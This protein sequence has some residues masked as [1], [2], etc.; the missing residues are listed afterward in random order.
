MFTEGAVSTVALATHP[1]AEQAAPPEGTMVAVFVITAG[2]WM[3]AVVA[4]ML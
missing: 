3:L 1:A 4:V 2:S